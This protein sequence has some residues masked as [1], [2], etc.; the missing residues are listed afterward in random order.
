MTYSAHGFRDA[1]LDRAVREFLSRE[2]AAR[3]ASIERSMRESPI[4]KAAS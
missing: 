1:Q 4:F 3:E 2:T